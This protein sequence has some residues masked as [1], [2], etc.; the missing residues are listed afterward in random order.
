MGRGQLAWYSH[1]IGA[2]ALLGLLAGFCPAS[3]QEAPPVI[4]EPN[5]TFPAET[6]VPANGR[7]GTTGFDAGN[8][9]TGIPSVGADEDPTA[10]SGDIDGLEP[11]PRIGQRAIAKDGDVTSP[12]PPALRD[13]I[14][15]IGEPAVIEDGTDPTTIDS[16]TAEEIAPF[17]DTAPAAEG[18]T[19]LFQIEDLD[20]V[21]DNRRP[22]RL[23]RNQPFDPVGIRI[24]SFVLFP[25][26]ELGGAWF[27]NVFRAPSASSDIAA[28][29]KPSMRLVSNWSTHAVE[30]RANGNLSFYND[31]D[32]ENDKSY[33]VEGR[34][35]LDV[36]RKT[37]VQTLI[38]REQTQESRSALDASSV[39]TRANLLTDRAEATLNHKFNRLGLQF[40]GSVSDFA[41][42]E[43]Q[44]LGV[45]TSNA[46]RDYKAYEEAVRATWELKP[47][48][49]PFAE[50]AI[51][52][53][54]Y[55]GVAASDLISRTSQGQRY[56]LGVSFG[57]T[58]QIL[59]GEVSLGY[60]VQNPNDGRLQSLD[61]LLIDANATWR[62]TDL[63]SL[64][65]T[66]RSDVSETSTA[67]VGGAFFRSLAVE[68][69]H[70]LRSYLIGSAGL[71][72]ATQDS[73]DGI[74]KESELRA[75]LGLEYYL[76]REALLFGNYAHTTFDALGT[77]SDYDADEVK[78]GMRLRR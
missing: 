74:I 9:A 11:V 61:G 37:S 31:F 20:P 55:D 24:G 34:G 40:R 57:N 71:S 2:A 13:G 58:S 18:G 76:N 72:Y 54:A 59:R 52:Q 8:P 44:N 65:F 21:L 33:L 53:R 14:V 73:L 1:G 56:R 35:R 36:T 66:A 78:V 41:F 30:L 17:Q 15:D 32:S 62:V 26:I 12:E 60:G 39:G 43:T 68:A 77:A 42:G 48:L 3:A 50:V 38:S 25:E 6:S 7:P 63:T 22:D 64:L 70:S 51:N 47:T 67:N 23:F 4:Q 45:V 27:S 49:L 5:Q 75:T 29:V 46:S 28:S 10:V 69:R 16:R 19:L